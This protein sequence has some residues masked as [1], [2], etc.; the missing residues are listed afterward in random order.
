V[1]Y[2]DSAAT[3]R[4]LPEVKVAMDAAAPG[5]P[6]S[7]HAVGRA[8][9]RQVEDARESVARIVGVDPKEVVFTSGATEANNLAILGTVDRGS[10]VVTTAIEHPSVLEAC[11]ALDGCEITRVI[12]DAEGRVRPADVER[13]IASR[14]ALVSVMLANNEVGTIQPVEEI[15]AIA[16][17]RRVLLHVDA[18]QACGKLKLSM[19]GDLLT[20]SAHKM[21]GPKGV[22]A[23]IVRRGTRLRP[24][25]FGGGQE[26]ER[27]A[28]TENVAGILGLARAAELG[29]RDRIARMEHLTRLSRA[30]RDGIAAMPD[31]RIHSPATGVLPHIVNASFRGVDGEAAIIALDAE[32][33]CASSGSACASQSLEPSHVL[34]AMGLPADVARGSLRFSFGVENTDEDV[35]RTLGVLRRVIDRLRRISTAV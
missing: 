5:N 20:L 6:S 13:A 28:G 23:L 31:S 8:A 29:E 21:H 16:K 32:G 2:L 3:T 26:F 17:T 33:V 18:A 11:G 35:Q 14:T 10:H 9:R 24:R 7:I 12:V 25:L 22:G 19:I 4:L 15:A 34:Q 30:L 27:R 1:I